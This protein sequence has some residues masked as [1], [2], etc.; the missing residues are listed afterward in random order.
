MSIT[1]S[2]STILH[3]DK[4]KLVFVAVHKYTANYVTDFLSETRKV[5]Q[6]LATKFNFSRWYI[7]TTR[8]L[9]IFILKIIFYL[10]TISICYGSRPIRHI[11]GWPQIYRL[12][13]DQRGS[14]SDFDVVEHR[15][16]YSEICKFM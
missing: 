3:F 2:G 14:N 13:L 10:N 6:I 15:I 1:P 12:I 4:N 16:F 5:T 11:V 8:K 7:Q 9:Y